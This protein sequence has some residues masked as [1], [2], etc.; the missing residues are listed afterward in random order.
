MTRSGA[1]ESKKRCHDLLH[2]ESDE[3]DILSKSMHFPEDP[4][5]LSSEVWAWL[6]MLIKQYRYVNRR[7]GPS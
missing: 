3:K 2:R 6:D 4:E 7:F 1:L 5:I